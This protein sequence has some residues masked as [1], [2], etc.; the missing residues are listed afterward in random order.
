M[1]RPQLRWHRPSDDFIGLVWFCSGQ[2]NN[3]RCRHGGSNNGFVAEIS[4]WP[5]VGRGAVVLLNSNQGAPLLS[6]VISAIA[7]EFD[8]LPTHSI[9]S[10]PVVHAS[11]YAGLYCGDGGACA[12]VERVGDQLTLQ[13]EGQEPVPLECVSERS[14][15]T[16]VLKLKVTFDPITD[17][18][19]GRMSLAQGGTTLLV[20]TRNDSAEF[21]N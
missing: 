2:E 21:R 16:S 6:E 10:D 15:V 11:N 7:R 5:A 17:A 20:L 19:S 4:L 13:F 8:W 12:N 3:L 9:A 14:F 1:L 18:S